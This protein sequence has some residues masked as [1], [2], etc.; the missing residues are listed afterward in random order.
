M[1]FTAT[2]ATPEAI[3]PWRDLH[4][5]EM[6]C[7]ITKDSLSARKG[8]TQ[9]YFLAAGGETA[10][11]GLIAIAGPWKDKPTVVEFYVLPDR[12][13]RVFDLFASLLAA[14]GAAFVEA[15]TNDT[16]LTVMLHAFCRNV[17]SESIVFHDKLTTA[18]AAPEAAVF[19]PAT[20][21]DAAAIAAAHLDEGAGW[22]VEVG[23]TVA[24][25]GGILFHYN[26]PYGDI[27]MAVA[28]PFRRR[29]LGSYLVQ[30]LKRVCYRDGNVP[31]AR[32]NTTNVA[33]R[34]T[35][36]KAGFVP[37]GHILSGS[38]H[39]GAAAG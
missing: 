30:E 6:N 18:H 26:R 1:E 23:G 36:Q 20:P 27:Y 7:Q 17:A 22:L 21:E 8:W 24:A 2:A 4:R 35:L 3:L 14:S 5:Q 29:G 34:R 39:A 33:S 9:P 15:Q 37:C 32:C 12:R 13:G 28:E 25:T 38:V 31:A 11:Y 16:L 19:R 10:G